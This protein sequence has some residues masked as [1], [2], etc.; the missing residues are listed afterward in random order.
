MWGSGGGGMEEDT[1][2]SFPE[3]PRVVCGER[4]TD[5]MPEKQRLIPALTPG[6]CDCDLIW[7]YGLCRCIHLRWGHTGIG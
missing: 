7:K 4:V 2:K 3:L 6:P 1:H 5:T